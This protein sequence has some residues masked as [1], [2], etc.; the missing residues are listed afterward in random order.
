[1]VMHLLTEELS[2]QVAG[3]ALFILLR[4][5]HMQVPRD[6]TTIL[7]YNATNKSSIS[8]LIITFKSNIKKTL[9]TSRL[10]TSLKL[11]HL[12]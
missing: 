9:K 1:M 12:L 5:G 10:L 8:L 7:E 11:E 2:L 6:P 4:V 3:T